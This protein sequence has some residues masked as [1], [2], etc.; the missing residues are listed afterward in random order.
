MADFR[1]L[2]GQPQAVNLLERA[3]ACDHLAPAYL[4]YG[5]AGIGKRTAARYFVQA[6]FCHSR[7]VAEHPQVIKLLQEANHP[8][9]LWVEPT[10]LNQGKLLTAQEAAQAGLKRKAPPQIRLEQIREITRYLSRKPLSAPRSVVV[11]EQAETM[12]EA[13]ANALL[14]T[15]EEP[16]Q[17]TLI[18]LSISETALLPTI[19]SRCARVPFYRLSRDLVQ[20][21]LHQTGHAEILQHTQIL[22]LAQGS[23]GMAI[24]AWQQFQSLPLDLQQKIHQLP[25][26]PRSALELAKEIDQHLEL[27]TQLWLL[28]YLQHHYWQTYQQPQLLQPLETA[29]KAL[30]NYVSSRLVWE[31]TCLNLCQ[32]QG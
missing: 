25:K 6:L 24:A 9:L 7:P 15:L 21:V 23:P 32:N 2:L 1:D 26:T 5:S 29:R 20:Q 13:A 16:G 14:K 12:A 22:A 28:D 17:A 31:V 19:V 10:Y 27:E 30:L 4:F 3:I 11:I 8:D 18:L